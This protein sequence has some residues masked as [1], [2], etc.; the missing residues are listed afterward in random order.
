MTN[1][2]DTNAVSQIIRSRWERKSWKTYFMVLNRTARDL[3]DLLKYIATKL[4]NR[5]RDFRL[6]IRWKPDNHLLLLLLTLGNSLV[7]GIGCLLFRFTSAAVHLSP[8][9][10]LLVGM[11][12]LNEF[13]IAIKLIRDAML[14]P[15]ET[16]LLIAINADHHLL[17]QWVPLMQSD[18]IL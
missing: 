17:I 14:Y 2:I 6:Y 7:K 3:L 9:M 15:L 18:R 12:I 8:H 5:R 13:P 16:E 11:G 1:Y 10:L 4:E